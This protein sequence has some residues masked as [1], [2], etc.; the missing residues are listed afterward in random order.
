VFGSGPFIAT[1]TAQS[2]SVNNTVT[3]DGTG[4]Y[5]MQFPFFL[6]Q[7][8][9]VIQF[10]APQ[11]GSMTIGGIFT[12]TCPVASPTPTINPSSTAT[13]TPVPVTGTLTPIP[14]FTPLPS[15]HNTFTRTPTA[16]V[17]VSTA[18]P[19]NTNTPA[20]GTTEWN[21]GDVTFP[22]LN[23]NVLP[24]SLSA[25]TV[26]NHWTVISNQVSGAAGYVVNAALRGI[27]GGTNDQQSWHMQA[28]APRADIISDTVTAH[29]TG[30]LYASYHADNYY[31]AALNNISIAIQLSGGSLQYLCGLDTGTDHCSGVLDLGPVTSGG[32][33]QISMISCN[34]S[35][36]TTYNTFEYLVKLDNVYVQAVG[37]SPTWT[38]TPTVTG[39]ATSGV[40]PGTVTSTP[41]PS[42]TPIPIPG[43]MSTDIPTATECPGGCVV[44]QLTAIPGMAT[45][46]TVDT[47]PFSPFTSLSLARSTCAPF[48]YVAIPYP[49]VHGTPAYGSTTPLSVT[50]TVPITAPWDDTHPFSNTAIQPCAMLN[51][52]P[53]TVWDFTYWFTVFAIAVVFIMWLIGFVGRLSGEETIN[54]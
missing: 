54:G 36:C 17:P 28:S 37:A 27:A 25:Y 2:G 11:S 16:T 50:W 4:N 39:T 3:I 15:G 47:S 1:A 8:T 33:Y 22:L 20:P 32:N 42:L 35:T 53:S 10:T 49:V 19:T 5:Y 45:R 48:G 30:E 51:E 31:S 43:A 7:N 13:N 40:T 21:C 23:C 12:T 46:V 18:T 38:N 29:A 34:A 41:T 6:Q 44:T 24:L 26:A 14:T 9:I 52:I